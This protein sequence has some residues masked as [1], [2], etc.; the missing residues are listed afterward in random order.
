MDIF[1]VL[2]KVRKI[3]HLMVL[4]SGVLLPLLDKCSVDADRHAMGHKFFLDAQR[5]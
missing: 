1:K 3:I 2:I 4:F 5:K